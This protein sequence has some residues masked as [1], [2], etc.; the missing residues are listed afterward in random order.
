MH[1]LNKTARLA[2]ALYLLVVISGFFTLMYV[3]GKLFV[4]NNGSATVSNILAHQSLFRA[5]IVADLLSGLAFI[6]TVLALYQLLKAFGRRL[7][8]VMVLLVLLVAPLGF[9]GTGNE[10]AALAL[11]RGSDLLAA[12]DPAQRN[13]L[14]LMLL[15]W[16]DQAGLVSELFWG[17]WLFPL[18]LLSYRSGFVPRFLAVWLLV[19]G[20]TYVVLSAVGLLWP[21]YPTM[22]STIATPILLGEVVFTL[23]LLV[24]GVRVP[25]TPVAEE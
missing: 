5:Y 15:R 7:A 3:P 25:P 10:V 21:H 2:G 12:F 17:L 14:A 6:A 16:N 18:G 11:L 20:L 9:V 13:A 24:L 22:I 4:P 1:P 8:M 19:N 23:W